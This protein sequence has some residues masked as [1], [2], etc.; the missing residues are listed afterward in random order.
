MAV[1]SMIAVHPKK[2][3]ELLKHENLFDEMERIYDE[4]ARRAF[5]IFEDEGGVFGRD[6]DHWLRAES[7]LLHPVP[8]EVTETDDGFIIHA[9]V[10]GFSPKELDV[11]IEPR[12]ITLTGKRESKEDKKKGKTI[13]RQ[14]YADQLFR[15]VDL[16]AEINTEKVKA[17]LE[18]GVLAL[19]MPKATPA[20][21]IAVEAKVA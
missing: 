3:Q 14:Q 2:E 20:K 6:L 5:E 4:I 7:E 13:Y 8:I 21:K 10:P 18:N 1:H 9:E 11:S 16:P 12:R 19:E 17:T 15:V